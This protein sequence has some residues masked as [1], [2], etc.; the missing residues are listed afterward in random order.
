MGSLVTKAAPDFSANAVLPDG[1][2]KEGF[3]LSS[4]KGRYVVL[5]FYPM[6]FTFV[7][8][9][10]IL[11]FDAELGEFE[12]RNVQVIGVSVDSEYSHHAWR[13]QERSK[14]GIGKIGFPLVADITKRIS[15][16][17]GV[18]LDSGVALRGL[19]LID[20][21]GLVR[22]ELVND[23]PLGR[24]TEEALRIVDALQTFEEVGEVCPANFKKGGK[25]MQTSQRGKELY[26]TA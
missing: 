1:A 21:S 7:C 4:F 13:E 19:F 23:L 25:T 26:F 3:K 14:G 20:K 11:A 15:A 5:F 16:D 18:L 2:I 10:E 9:T 12:K 6:D 8:P 17:Y 22:H 24:S